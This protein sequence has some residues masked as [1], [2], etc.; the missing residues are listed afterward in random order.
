MAVLTDMSR[1]LAGVH[2]AETAAVTR[3]RTALGR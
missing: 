2:E 3:L 1:Q